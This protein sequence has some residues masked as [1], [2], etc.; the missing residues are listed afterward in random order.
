MIN[1]YKKVKISD[2]C[3]I[4]SSKRIFAKE[5]QE[6]GVPFY[7]G[8]EITEK[9]R[10][11]LNISTELYIS[12]KKYQEI[13]NKHGVPKAGDLLLTSV[14]TLGSTYVVKE[15]D[16]FY[17]K[18]GNIT[19][20][21]HLDNLDSYYLKYWF[22]S[23]E[24]KAELQKSIIGSSQSA[25]TI[26]NLKNMKISLPPLNVQ[27]KIVSILS[28]YD[29]LIENNNRRITILEEMAQKLYREWFV[30][31]RFPGYEE[32]KMVELE[33]G[34]IPEGW[35]VVKM[36]ELYKTSSGG[37]PSRKKP[38][39]YDDGDIPWVKTKE[40]KDSF[41]IDSEEKI[42]EL[43][44]KGSSAKLFPKYSV[45]MAMYGATIGQLGILSQE[46][47]SNQ[48][49]CAVIAKDEEFSP[50]Y[51][52]LYLYSNRDHIIG[53]RMG[54]AQQNISQQII[55]NLFILKPTFDTMKKFNQIVTPLFLQIEN[56]QKKNLNL[57]SQRDVLLPKL[58]SG[59]IEVS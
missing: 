14:G 7:R 37:T 10:G 30:K 35:E 3:D 48:A 13:K 1:N 17:F 20:F 2:V 47:A 25:Y 5:Y 31:F 8:K 32:V 44:L 28:T 41:V 16:R 42:T 51:V 40:L 49:C 36:S 34:L 11:N 53:Q 4:T 19:W 56:L 33:L 12:E 21:R 18:D 29:D 6:K 52:Y 9:Y 57:K 45:L 23:P 43:G 46:A 54:A 24:G 15:T 27:K 58:I 22:E 55:K 39:Y 26:A 38:E 59:K 50:W